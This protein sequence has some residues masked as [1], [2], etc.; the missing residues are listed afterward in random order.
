[1]QVLIDTHILIWWWAEDPLL[2]T[3]LRDLMA[4]SATNVYVS[5]VSALEL[6][7]K[8]RLGRLAAMER[9]IHEFHEGVVSDGFHHLTIHHEHARRAG[10]LPGEHR[11]PFDRVLAAQSLY[12]QM[13]IITAD[14]QIAGFGCKVIW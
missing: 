1:M 10:L 12:E 9:R 7:I 6:G 14:P 13:P 11:D 5:A 2:P 8:V 3:A 4:D